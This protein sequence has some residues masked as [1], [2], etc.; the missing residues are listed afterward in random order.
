MTK[1]KLESIVSRTSMSLPL[2]C[3]SVIVCTPLT[4]VFRERTRLQ[5]KVSGESVRDKLCTQNS[6]RQLPY[7]VAERSIVLR[8]GKRLP[9]V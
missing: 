3:S 4:L 6:I 2:H 9:I 7:L 5:R 8:R 1:L